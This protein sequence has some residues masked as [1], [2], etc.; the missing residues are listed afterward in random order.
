MTHEEIYSG[1][2]LIAKFMGMVPAGINAD[3]FWETSEKIVGRGTG[4][5]EYHSSWNW[6]MLVVEK[7]EKQGFI[8]VIEKNSRTD[9]RVFFNTEDYTS[10]ANGARDEDKRTAIWLAVVDFIKWYNKQP[11]Y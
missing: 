7:I 5:L 9:H 8:S 6:L 3:Y 10:V 11:K 2:K 1:N 4:D